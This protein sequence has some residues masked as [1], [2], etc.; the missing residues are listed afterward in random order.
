MKVR[1]AVVLLLTFALLVGAVSAGGVLVNLDSHTDHTG[2]VNALSMDGQTVLSGSSG[3]EAIAWTGGSIDWNN[4]GINTEIVDVDANGDLYYVVGSDRSVRLI[5]PA[6]GNVVDEETYFASQGANPTSVAGDGF[7]IL[8][9]SEIGEVALFD[10]E[11]FYYHSYYH[12]D[13]VTAVGLLPDAMVSADETGTVKAATLGGAQ[14]FL[15]LD[16]HT[17]PVNAMDTEHSY[18]VVTGGADGNVA[19]TDVFNEIVQWTHGHHGSNEVM[20]V[21]VSGDF[22]V[23][24]DDSGTVVVADKGIGTLVFEQSVYSGSGS[25]VDITGNQ[26]ATSSLSGDV[27]LWDIEFGPSLSN[28]DPPTNISAS[29]SRQV[30]VDY[31]RADGDT[32]RLLDGPG[33]NEYDSWTV[34]GSG[35]VTHTI[36]AD[37]NVPQVIYWESYVGF[38]LYDSAGPFKINPQEP[39]LSNAEPTGGDLT[40]GDPVIISVDVSDDDF[41]TSMGDTV[42]VTFRE[43]DGTLI[44]SHTLTEDGTVTDEYDAGPGM[45]EWYVEAS[46]A[47]GNSVT[48]P[49]HTFEMPDTL[50]VRDEQTGELL[51][52][53]PEDIELQI[54]GETFSELR[55]TSDGTINMA[56]LPVNERLTVTISAEGYEDRRT[57]VDSL[58][59]E[60]D[61]FLLEEDPENVDNILRVED[62]TGSFPRGTTVVYVN[63]LI[64]VD[65]E[66]K[67]RVIAADETG[68]ANEVAVTLQS[69]HRYTIMVENRAGDRRDLGQYTPTLSGEV[70]LQI[71]GEVISVSRDESFSV[72]SYTVPTSD[73]T[74]MIRFDYTDPADLTTS[75]GVT[76]Y[77]R[78]NESNTI[79]D[80]VYL[81]GSSSQFGE[82]V[83]EKTLTEEESDLNWVVDYQ[84][85]RDGE[86]INRMTTVG[87]GAYGFGIPLGDNWKSVISVGIMI[88]VGALFSMGNVA[89]GAI[90]VPSTAGVFF[91]VDWLPGEIAPQ[92]IVIA[93][94][95]AVTYNL[96]VRRGL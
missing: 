37:E 38:D 41:S 9:G 35:T 26:M 17:G 40:S 54:Q 76:I 39:V 1:T 63:R 81:P 44:G 70:T 32:I 55:T 7:L 85:E 74:D 18:T 33:G 64:E 50:F 92:A 11:P 10:T 20:D 78:G 27:S 31:E 82:L 19:K 34:S 46:D 6:N 42:E 47:Y 72:R 75:V 14:V 91:L 5:D 69:G 83:V 67:P 90:A 61:V 2:S 58:F 16:P 21:A 93:L 43:G 12:T 80:E 49:V 23:S 3:G 30:S 73:T 60:Q 36:Q 24:I 8:V 65:G 84:I 62:N 88:L 89:A 77:E 28:P 48:S 25:G 45:N 53:L 56:G 13:P 87:S 95:I 4:N 86:T 68:A 94:A 59:R 66:T 71:V 29:G 22:V 52:D 79:H 96:A 57:V 51:D 15:T